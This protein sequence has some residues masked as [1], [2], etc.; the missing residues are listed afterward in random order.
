MNI[1]AARPA[2][3]ERSFQSDTDWSVFPEVFES[4]CS[5]FRIADGVLNVLVAEVELNRARIL[6][7]VGEIKLPIRFQHPLIQFDGL[8]RGFRLRLVGSKE[9]FRTLSVD[10]KF[11]LGYRQPKSCWLNTPTS[12]LF[13]NF[14]SSNSRKFTRNA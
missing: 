8:L 13:A 3:R 5:Q 1:R 11:I 6:A 2:S 7:G 10:M 14:R 4:A 9:G 12:S